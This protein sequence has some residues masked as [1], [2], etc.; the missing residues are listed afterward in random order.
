VIAPGACLEEVEVLSFIEDELPAER[1]SEIVR[2]LDA[3]DACRRRLNLVAQV[4]SAESAVPSATEPVSPASIDRYKVIG[5]RARGGQARILLAFD[6]NVGRRVALK[7]LLPAAEKPGSDSSWRDA[8]ARFLREAEL[9]GQLVH[10]GVVPV[11]EIGQRPN[12]ALFYSMQL[13]RG[14]TL[15][16]VLRQ[17]GSVTDRLSLLS[18]FL[19]V[20]HVV[21]YAHSRGVLH[22]DIKPQN[23]MVGEFGETV[24]LDWGLAKQRDEPD[25]F[26]A[27]WAQASGRALST[28]TLE[29]TIMG[30]PGYMSPEQACGRLSEVDDRSDIYGLGAVLF[31][32]LTGSRPIL[33]PDAG[34]VPRARSLCKEVPPELAV[35]AEKALAP[36]KDDRYQQAL[37]LAKD[38]TAFMTGG[39]VAAYAYTSRDLL[40]RFAARHRLILGAAGVTLGAIV[41]ALILLS[42]A[43]RSELAS[44]RAAAE[45]GREALQEG[46]ELALLQGDTFQAR[47]KLRGALELGDSLAV[48]ALWRKLRV[49]PERFVAHS[50][51]AGYTVRFSPNGHEL[52]VGLQ[53]ASLQFIDLV[54]RATRTLRGSDDQ[55]T[56][57]AYSPDASFLASGGPSGRVVLWDLKR[58]SLTRLG[59]PADPIMGIG[60]SSGGS[61]LA[62]GDARG[63]IVQW[64]ARSHTVIARQQT[65]ADKVLDIAFSSD[66]R[67]AALSSRDNKILLWDLGAQAPLLELSGPF[68]GLVFGPDGSLLAAGGFD[69]DVYLWQKVGDGRP[70]QVLRGH[71]QRVAHLAASSDGRLLASASADRTVRLWSL[72]EGRAVRVLSAGDGVFDVAFSAD[73]TLLAAAAD[74]TTWVWDLGTH[75]EPAALPQPPTK[76]DIARFS[77]DGA[78][79]VSA[80]EDGVVRRW[81]ATSGEMLGS[82]D[83]HESWA[84]DVCFSPDGKHLASVGFDGVLVMR[85]ALTGAVQ[86]RLSVGGNGLAAVACSPENRNVASGGYD[87]AVHIWDVATGK[88]ERTLESPA[89]IIP[90]SS[91]LYSSDGRRLIAGR[92]HGRIDVWDAASG[93][94]MRVIPGHASGFSGVALDAM[95]NILALGSDDHS[96]SLWNMADGTSRVLG[97]AAGRVWGIGWDPRGERLAAAIST[98]EI[99]VFN[100]G[101]ARP[102]R[103]AAHHSEANSIQF[104]PSGET[105][106]SAGDDGTIRLWDTANWQPKWFTRSLVYDPAP[107]ILTHQG[108]RAADLSRQLKPVTLPGSAWRRAVET[109]KEAVSQPGGPVCVV[110]DERMEIWDTASDTRVLAENVT[111]GTDIVA[112]PGGCSLL[113]DGRVMLYRPGKSSME[114][115]R[116]AS[117]QIGGEKLVV[118]GSEVEL[119]D[120]EGRSLGTFGAGSGVTA[121]APL[122]ERMAVGFRDGGIELRGRGDQRA[123]SFQDT[124]EG[125]ATRFAEG[126]NGTLAAGFA[127]GSFAVWSS[128]SGARLEHG[129]VH[130]AVRHLIIHEQ[131]L[132]VASEVGSLASMD[133]SVLTTDYCVLLREVWS[134]VPVL[135]H[136]GVAVARE[137]NRGHPCAAWQ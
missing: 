10:P 6:E 53:E 78:H 49:A 130:G 52:A 86:H 37:E 9:T 99:E 125:A 109:A 17:R 112:V 11:F 50:S 55:I 103:F 73:G 38:V 16:E 92:R 89:S 111:P 110:N 79:I 46:A 82:W 131:L 88:K 66:G 1:R 90:I 31:E 8:K 32:I 22:R 42:F 48:R 123:V 94:L 27:I 45:Q 129:A 33:A 24:L 120:R 128:S 21:A 40:R 51:A 122:G 14:R 7:E 84:T 12:G 85:D 98:G 39:R 28:A 20:C 71:Q 15:S 3:C 126:P 23:I 60:F 115:A 137:P 95:G 58:G 4:R 108:W 64:D 101:D 63:R 134:R 13:V 113:K 59:E 61:L 54:T 97:V 119:F 56:A 105:A 107:Q 47:A 68:N 18:H 25:A 81:D 5:E 57:V 87:G 69:G 96:V 114:I 100:R 76:I 136:D 29:G 116:G 36:N 104:S 62:A 26:P 127:D 70:P 121:A 133:L 35:I 2:H 93:R 132:I 44:R 75:E 83:D 102:L 117:L 41:T 65:A 43:W 19:S 106:V 135:W 118:V 124:P 80:S 72:P 74:R 67:R 34:G 91:L 30:T 77:P